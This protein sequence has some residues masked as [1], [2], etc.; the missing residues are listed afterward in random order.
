MVE[1]VEANALKRI[2]DRSEQHIAHV[3]LPSPAVEITRA[4]HRSASRSAQGVPSSSS[5]TIK[6]G[7][8]GWSQKQERESHESTL[9]ALFWFLFSWRGLLVFIAVCLLHQRDFAPCGSARGIRAEA[10]WIAFLLASLRCA[11]SGRLGG[12][13]ES[14]LGMI[15]VWGDLARRWRRDRHPRT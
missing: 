10:C 9:S 7:R 2:S 6:H 5:S 3:P 1:T 8:A 13:L 15:Y 12:L 4:L 11:I 14:T